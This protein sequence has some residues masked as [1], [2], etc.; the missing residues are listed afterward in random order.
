MDQLVQSL[1][2]PNGRHIE[3][4]TGLFINNK[5]V[6]G[7][8]PK[9]VSVNPAN[10]KAIVS[11]EAASSVEV[12]RA[13]EAAQVAFNQPTWR[14]LPPADRGALLSKLADLID[15]DREILATLESWDNG[16]PYATAL[17]EDI[18]ET[19]TTLRYYAGWS[20]KMAGSTFYKAG[21]TQQKL[22]YTI[23]QPIGVCAQIIP[24]NYPLSMASWKL[25]P[26]IACGNT[27]VL[28]PAEQTPLSILH[29]ASLVA[30]AGFPAGVINIINGLGAEAGQALVSHK[31]I[32]KIA[33]T[34][35]TVTAKHI[36]RAAAMNLTNIT[37]ETGGKSPLIVFDDA[38]LE[39]AAK[40][41][42]L[43]IMSNQGQIC[44]ATSRLLVQREV[45]D[46]FLKEFLKVIEESTVIGDPFEE[47]TT[48][49][50]QVSR[51]Q[52]ERI[53]DFVK[54]GKDQGA[55]L[56]AGGEHPNTE[57]TKGG[58]FVAPT[59]FA[60]VTSDMDIFQQEIF[61]PFAVVTPFDTEEESLALANNSAYGLGA[62][63][64]S[65]DVER[66][67]RVAE[68]IDAGMVWVNSSQDA[69]VR[70]PFGGVKQSG[71]GRELGEAVLAAYTQE[72]AIHLN[73]G[74]RI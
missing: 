55:T 64:F 38:D 44:T 1:V 5:F 74:L 12:D 58:F 47:T 31:G 46:T 48:Q 67:H 22:G 45:Y 13:V 54:I 63:V 24:W 39:Q 73:L 41:A 20:D 37:L 16:K 8:A 68:R 53:L 29:L 11:V 70:M 30:K 10:G 51:Q 59:V 66:V 15:N 18:A 35:S 43:G 49:G 7:S 61:G 34:G 32:N 50:P 25:G 21:Y 28:K 56:V 65:R 69:D 60:N 4:N 6:A 26:A 62:A 42:H 19:T 72:K 3:L 36:M 71:I 9:I 27:V 2:A 33:F 14:D 57:S 52:Y 23:K 17:E 40:W